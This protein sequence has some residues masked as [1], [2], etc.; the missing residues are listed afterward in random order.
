MPQGH[1][2]ADTG[3]I[4][5]NILEPV[6]LDPT[7]GFALLDRKRIAYQLIGAGPV[8]LLITAGYWG[9][10]DVEWEDPMIR[11]FYEQVGE[12]SRIIR[13]DRL[14]SGA[15]DPVPVDDLPPWESFAQEIESV[16]DAVGSES[17]SLFAITDAGPPAML[18]AAS[19]P[20][21]CHSLV[22]FNSSARELWADD[23][24]FGRTRDDVRMIYDPA[25][26]PDW[27]TQGGIT[28]GLYYPSKAND[29]RFAR[30]FTRFQRAIASPEIAMHY[31]VATTQADA[32][33][34]LQSLHVPTVVMHRRASPAVRIEH[35]QYLAD[36]IDGARFVELPGG[37]S[38]P[39]WETPE[40][41]IAELQELLGTGE[42]TRPDSRTL[43]TLLFTDI[44]DSTRRADELGDRRW[45]ALLNLHDELAE[46]VL[47]AYGGR[48]VKTTGDGILAT[49]DGPGKAIRAARD[50]GTELA[51]LQLTIRCGIHTGEIELRGDDVAGLTVHIASRVMATA[52]AEEV[53]VTSIVKDLAAGS[54]ALFIDRGY[55]TLKGVGGEWQL[56]SVR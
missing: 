13:F 11:L 52:G 14:G 2:S 23:Y 29:Q 26:I 12:F 48:L 31:A 37:D 43:A 27:G 16:L 44:V 4:Q 7:F 47:S 25:N 28:M 9:S 6:T 36:H 45:R 5:S 49:L 32:R 56:Y 42:A 33:P 22:L 21:R 30:W 39:Y 1:D 40:L 35:G 15:S 55:H 53:F 41:I 8:D 34:L 46:K 18:F 51:R 24:T 19:R 17:V 54:D 50:L 3:R 38:F 10:F 20:E